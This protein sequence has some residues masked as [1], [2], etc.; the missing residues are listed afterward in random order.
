MID[1]V[2][3][4]P[5]QAENEPV[6]LRERGK[7]RRTERIL[8][9]ALRLLREDP[10]QNLTIDRIAERAEVA[11][12]TVYNLIGTRDQIWT[13]LVNRALAEIDP[14]SITAPD[15]Q[16]RARRI[17]AA[18]VRVLRADAPVFAAL[19]TGWSNSGRVLEDDPT[20]ALIACLKDAADAGK[21]NAD[22]DVRYHGEVLAA[23]L[24]GT[25]HQ[26]T[27]GLLSDRAFA[28]RAR[29]VVDVV[30]AA[31]RSPG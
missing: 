31:A 4:R 14:T 30:F 8:D 15:P 5:A 27:A 23:G 6:G 17:V 22:A 19:L 20:N 12:M 7:Q 2:M 16:E 13:A 11:P 3:S 24:L 9:A 1:A 25:I 18:Y 10:E 29:A 21:I 28:A 26:W